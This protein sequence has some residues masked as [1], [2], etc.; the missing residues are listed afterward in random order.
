MCDCKIPT[1]SN[2]ERLCKEKLRISIFP[3]HIKFLKLHVSV[4]CDGLVNYSKYKRHIL[5]VKNW[6]RCPP[7]AKIAIDAIRNIQMSPAC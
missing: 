6:Q 4:R 3:L 1:I 5:Y 2:C 7:Y